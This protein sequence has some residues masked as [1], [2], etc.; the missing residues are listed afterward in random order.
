MNDPRDRTLCRTCGAHVFFA[1]SRAA[2]IEPFDAD[3]S[4]AGTIR[5]I[6]APGGGYRA[7]ELADQ[8]LTDARERGMPLYVSHYVRCP[9]ADM[10]SN[11]KG[12]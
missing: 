2:V 12:D 7:V 11:R 9:N 4:P 8:R 5:V 10:S 1:S 3:P 6:P